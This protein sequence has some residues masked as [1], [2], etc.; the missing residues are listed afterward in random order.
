MCKKKSLKERYLPFKFTSD[1]LGNTRDI[2]V[3]TPSI[4]SNT[5]GDEVL[6]YIFDAEAYINTVELLNDIWITCL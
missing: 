6:L 2:S 1:T 4:N 5:A 3:Y